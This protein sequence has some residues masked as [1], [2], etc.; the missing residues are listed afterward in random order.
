MNTENEI[1]EAIDKLRETTSNTQELYRETCALLF[2]RYGITPTA[3]KLYQFVKKGSMSAPSEAL[4]RFWEELREKSRV[5][6]EH[7]DL[8]DS[9]KVEAGELVGQLWGKAQTAAHESLNVFMQ[10][11]D[12]RVTAA[13]AER[14]R[15]ERDAKAAKMELEHLREALDGASERILS[16]ERVLAAESAGKETLVGQLSAARRQHTILEADISAARKDFASEL[17]KLRASLC[18]AEDRYEAAEKRAL[19][20]I[21]RER[22]SAA[23]IQKELVHVRQANAD[24]VQSHRNEVGAL[25]REL[26]DIRQDLGV[27]EG[28]LVKMKE[29]A[30]GYVVEM[31]VM[32]EKLTQQTTETALLRRELDIREEKIKSMA[33]ELR[34]THE[35]VDPISRPAKVK[36]PKRKT[37]VPVSTKGFDAKRSPSKQ[38]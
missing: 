27:A 5:R 34:Q 30:E 14:Q 38:R 2:F 28:S 10:E 6:I 37:S 11:A 13:D 7:P 23:K 1:R 17:E 26:G 29:A 33:H 31:D 32:R 16:L 12:A 15:A 20:E 24:L 18:R 22:T 19:L 25:Q 8:P 35:T 4:G 21:D 9:L 3:N 36:P